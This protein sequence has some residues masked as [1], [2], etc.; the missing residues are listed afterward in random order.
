MAPKYPCFV[1]NPATL[2]PNCQIPNQFVYHKVIHI[3]NTHNNI[4]NYLKMLVLW[5]LAIRVFSHYSLCL[6]WLLFVGDNLGFLIPRRLFV[7]KFHLL[8]TWLQII[9]KTMLQH[10][11]QHYNR[12]SNRLELLIHFHLEVVL[13]RT[14]FIPTTSR[15]LII[16]KFQFLRP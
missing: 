8:E 3:L 10:R 1:I 14:S 4:Q 13:I 6:E 2:K 11:I 16:N 9:I 12:I 7:E 15:L 5:Q